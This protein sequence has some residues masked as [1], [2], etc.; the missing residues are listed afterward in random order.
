[1]LCLCAGT[2]PPSVD[3]ENFLL[4]FIIERYEKS[5]GA[6]RDYAKY[7]LRMIDAMLAAGDASGFV[8]SVE[9]IQA[10]KERPPILATI[11]LVDGNV[12][13]EN[14]PVTP[15]LNVGNVLDNCLGWLDLKDK[16]SSSLGLFVYDLGPS[17]KGAVSTQENEGVYAD[18]PRTPRPLRNAEFMG[19]VIVRNSRQQRRFKFVMKKKIF[20][21]TNHNPEEGEES[22]PHYDRLVYLQAEDEVIIQGN[23]PCDSEQDAIELAS[24]SIAVA[25]NDDEVPDSVEALTVPGN[26]SDQPYVLEYVP[27]DFREEKTAEEWATAVVAQLKSYSSDMSVGDKQNRFVDIVAQSPL[28]GTHWFYVNRVNGTANQVSELPDKLVLGFNGEGL[29]VFDTEMT[30]IVSFTYGDI[31]RWGGS[32]SQF[33][34]ILFD[35]ETEEVFDLVVATAQASDMA[36]VILDHIESLMESGTLEEESEQV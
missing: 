7:C 30:F 29:H 34:I 4:H 12:I 32:P 26:D 9:E 36:S 8:P 13:T 1:M 28:Y 17:N 14:L 33:C 21:E 3:F 5:R 27:P 2:F 20:L 31:H 23:I 25:C 6:V 19:D 24:L 35:A 10:Y 11:E 18:L 22:D 15:D 16:R